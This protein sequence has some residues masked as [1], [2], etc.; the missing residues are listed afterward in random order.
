MGMRSIDMA[1]PLL[2]NTNG[3]T[4][5]RRKPQQTIILSRAPGV[6]KVRFVR[7]PWCV[8]NGINGSPKRKRGMFDIPRLR[9]GLPLTRLRTTDFLLL[10]GRHARRQR[11]Q[12]RE[13][14]RP[15]VV[16]E[17][18]V[19]LVRQPAVVQAVRTLPA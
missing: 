11:P 12:R 3:G 19:R 16:E 9:F 10:P 2:G 17:L 13:A 6:V 4:T 8:V 5:R 18:Q 1:Q 14:L 15:L 7:G